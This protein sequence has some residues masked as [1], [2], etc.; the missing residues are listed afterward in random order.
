MQC[1]GTYY[2]HIETASNLHNLL[3]WMEKPNTCTHIYVYVFVSGM[4]DE[5]FSD[6]TW[7]EADTTLEVYTII[8]VTLTKQPL[9]ELLY[10]FERAFA[11][12]YL[13][14]DN[15][16]LYLHKIKYIDIK[17]TYG[18]LGMVARGLVSM[19]VCVLI[20]IDILAAFS[21]YMN[22]FVWFYLHCKRYVVSHHHFTWLMIFCYQI[23]YSYFVVQCQ[24]YAT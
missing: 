5:S 3:E 10:S 7:R 18:K 2:T 20:D 6:Q 9:T 21:I 4:K 17:L 15:N 24:C 1:K 11:F 13:A 14:N 16:K 8:L 12:L 19:E 22:L 23:I